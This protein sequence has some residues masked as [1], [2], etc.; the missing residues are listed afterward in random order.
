V[1][2]FCNLVEFRPIMV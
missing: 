1:I 2:F